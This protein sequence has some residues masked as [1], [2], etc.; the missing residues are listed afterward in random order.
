MERK[1]EKILTKS[2]FYPEKSQRLSDGELLP[3]PDKYEQVTFI[4]HFV[5]A[6]L[7]FPCFRFVKYQMEITQQSFV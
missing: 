3:L 6:N 5:F 1:L 2:T 7:K 4:H